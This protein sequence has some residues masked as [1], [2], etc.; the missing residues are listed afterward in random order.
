MYLYESEA[1]N[2][3]VATLELPGMHKADVQVTAKDDELIVTGERRPVQ[4]PDKPGRS[5]VNE[6]KFGK[7]LR[8]IRLPAGTKVRISAEIGVTRIEL[9]THFATAHQHIRVDG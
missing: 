8:V 1:A 2:V 4:F 9:L 5:I 6:L 7:F 3:V